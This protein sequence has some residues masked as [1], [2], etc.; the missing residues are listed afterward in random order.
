MP[1]QSDWTIGHTRMWSE[2]HLCNAKDMTHELE[3]DQRMGFCL[4]DVPVTLKAVTQI[5]RQLF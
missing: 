5:E 2:Y 1:H 4:S 3:R